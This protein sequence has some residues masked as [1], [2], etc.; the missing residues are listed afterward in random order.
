MPK[1][2]NIKKTT[3]QPHDGTATASQ[4]ND[5]TNRSVERSRRI[6]EERSQ[7]KD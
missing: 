3:I 2:N 7:K 6:V 1:D 4:D 5:N